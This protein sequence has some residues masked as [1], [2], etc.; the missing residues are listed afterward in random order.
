MDIASNGYLQFDSSNSPPCV[1]SYFA[2]DN[3]RIW[4]LSMCF[5]SN[6]GGPK[7]CDLL[8][9]RATRVPTTPFPRRRNHRASADEAQLAKLKCS[10]AIQIILLPGGR[11]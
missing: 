1:S 9:V 5:M 11:D 3:R 8:I 4:P 6:W 7:T 10:H 2:L